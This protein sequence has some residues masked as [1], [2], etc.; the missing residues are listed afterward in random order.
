MP[1]PLSLDRLRQL[2]YPVADDGSMRLPPLPRRPLGTT[3]L[4]DQLDHIDRLTAPQ[5]VAAMYRG[6]LSYAQL[7]R[8]AARY[9]QEVLTLHGE[10]IFIAIG[11][12][13]IADAAT[14]PVREAA[15]ELSLA[16]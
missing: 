7:C 1:Q 5:R 16:A 2:G 8:W 10:F 3:G 14:V 13:E 4:Q 15:F 9:P 6:E 11:L 12:P